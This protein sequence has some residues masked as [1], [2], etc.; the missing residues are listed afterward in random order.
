[1]GFLDITTMANGRKITPGRDPFN[2]SSFPGVVDKMR[3]RTLDKLGRD[4]CSAAQMLAAND[5]TIEK[6]DI[7]YEIEGNELKV[8]ANQTHS[9]GYTYLKERALETGEIYRSE[10]TNHLLKASLAVLQGKS[11]NRN[12]IDDLA[13]DIVK[14][15]RGS[16]GIGSMS[17]KSRPVFPSF[18]TMAGFL[19]VGAAYYSGIPL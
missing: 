8:K 3:G 14:E 13:Y 7:S 4:I 18:A 2:L 19:A 6:L 17:G 15:W 9:R 16:R 5:T 12:T 10:P 11:K 1:M